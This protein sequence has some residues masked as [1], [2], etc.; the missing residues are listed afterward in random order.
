MLRTYLAAAGSSVLKRIRPAAAG[1]LSR[2][3]GPESPRRTETVTADPQTVAEFCR[4][5]GEPVRNTVP[6]TWLHAQGFAASLS[7][8]SAPDF[9]APAMGMVHVTN[10]LTQLH[11]VRVGDAVTATVW[12]DAIRTHPKGTEIVVAAAFDVDGRR[13]VDERCHYLAKGVRVDGAT[14]HDPAERTPFEAPDATMSWRL[15]PRTADTYA[16]VSGDVNPIHLNGL[17]AKAFGFRGRIVHGMYTAARALASAQIRADAFTWDVEFATP[18]VL[19]STVAVRVAHGS[20][21]T[22]VDV[23]ESRATDGPHMLSSI[24]T[25]SGTEN[26]TENGTSNGRQ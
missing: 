4:A 9:P 5:V 13:C 2:V 15:T 26:G 12:I 11:P 8:L 20:A 14:P 18:V 19:P 3:A 22:T 16:R 1:P 10:S 25:E 21:L 23:V 7:L 24:R 6:V 17:A